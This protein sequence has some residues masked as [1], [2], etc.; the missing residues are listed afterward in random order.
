MQPY[1]SSV[2]LPSSDKRW[3]LVDATMRRH[4]HKA[5]ALIEVLHTV[6]ESFASST[7]CRYVS[8]PLPCVFP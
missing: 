5:A 4:G 2:P 6:Q 1:P 3:K 7:R 8:S